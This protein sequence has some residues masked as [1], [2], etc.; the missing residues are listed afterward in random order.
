[1]VAGE[2]S[3]HFI[4]VCGNE[5]TWYVGSL[6]PDQLHACG[7]TLQAA[8]SALME[9]HGDR[10]AEWRILIAGQVAVH[11]RAGLLHQRWPT[12]ERLG[13]GLVVSGTWQHVPRVMLS[14][15]SVIG[16]R[17]RYK[18]VHRCHTSSRMLQPSR[19]SC[20]TL[21]TLLRSSGTM[22]QLLNVPVIS[23]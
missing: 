8:V 11:K 13:S 7:G 22:P 21:N 1:M 4:G 16:R 15:E 19:R 18:V 14:F 2:L 6:S 17:P 20:V 12:V 5:R 23:H 9:C 10:H 3:C